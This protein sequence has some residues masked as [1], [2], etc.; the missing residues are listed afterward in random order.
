MARELLQLEGAWV[1]IAEDGQQAVEAI[2]IRQAARTQ[3]DLVL[4]DLQMP[5]M[6]G[7]T[8]THH[9]RQ[10]MGLKNLPIV[11]MT[12]NALDSDRDAC[13]AAG[14]D[15]HVGKPF[16]L[17][18]LVGVLQRL[19]AP[20]WERPGAAGAER[21]VPAPVLA[22]LP[23]AQAEPADALRRAAQ[24]A[25]VDLVGALNRLGHNHALYE[26]TLSVFVADL[27]AMPAQLR[28]Q[29]LAQDA[30]QASRLLHT[31]KGLAATLGA[32]ALA[33]VAG[34]GE[35][36]LKSHINGISNSNSGTA[37]PKDAASADLPAVVARTCVAIAQAR[38][39]LIALHAALQATLQPATKPAATTTPPLDTA[40]LAL[41]LT[42]MTEKLRNFDMDAVQ[43]MATLKQQFGAALQGQ[44]G[45]SL[46]PLDDAIEALDFEQAR[47]L[48]HTLLTMTQDPSP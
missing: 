8:A 39:S 32:A 2:E 10:L 15:G 9:I 43:L 24:A 25:G 3:F 40:A 23:P 22:E 38:P 41:L 20:S 4:M 47:A 14:M 12:A 36:L 45:Q 35:A 1:Q 17:N 48:C 19:A 26:R 18:H 28:A 11:A 37:N 29:Q 30:T 16:D 46:K 27:H 33:T 21:A 42:A 6:D 5:V 13:L 7:F 34:E 31:L 44:T